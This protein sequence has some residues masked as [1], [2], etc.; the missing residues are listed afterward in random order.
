MAETATT[1]SLPAFAPTPVVG[2]K[3]PSVDR[4]GEMELDDELD[5]ITSEP[6]PDVHDVKP[7][8]PT[9]PIANLHGGGRGYVPGE[10]PEDPKKRHKCQICGRGFARAF[11]LKVSSSCAAIH[12]S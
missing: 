10:T 2:S 8:I 5:E 4:E 6:G 12:P 3:A 7:T 9:M 1:D 11:N